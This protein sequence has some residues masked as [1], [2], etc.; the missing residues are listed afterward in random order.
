MQVARY[1]DDRLGVVRGSSLHDVTA[2][3]NELRSRTSYTYMG[4][5]VIA[6]LQAPANRRLMAE[7]AGKAPG[8]PLASAKL[9]APV[10]RPTKLVCAPTNYHKHIEE[11]AAA[12][13]ARGS[14]HTARISEDGLFL[15]ANSALVGPGEG[16]AIRFPD[17]RNDHEAELVVV[18]G[19]QG[20]DIALDK[21]LD[22]VTGYSLG[23]DMTVRGGADRSF[24]KSPD[25]YAPLG[26]WL[27]TA[28]EIP[29]PDA[30]P[31]QLTVNG[32]LRQKSD[33]SQLIY[34][35]KRL[36]EF[37]SQYYTLYPGDLIYT[38]TPD[39]VGPVKA[40]DLIEVSSAPCLGTL[41]IAVRARSVS[42][43]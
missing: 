31:L 8:I 39:G 17:Q 32:E 13:V 38:G 21:A 26:P 27:V 33:T 43:T 14:K 30:L 6:F 19:K 24:R 12:R 4:D 34:G 18:I 35:V 3:Q 20:S 42:A 23:L 25:G 22:Y 29:D 15:K 16:I 9:L 11:M 5:P 7:A 10:A 36:I 40:G 37:A 2:L 41:R 1:G 28:D